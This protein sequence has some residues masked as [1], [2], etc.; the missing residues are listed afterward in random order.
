M[1]LGGYALQ[2]MT[3]YLRLKDVLSSLILL[4]ALKHSCSSPVPTE[5][6]I[7]VYCPRLKTLGVAPPR[8][9]LSKSNRSALSRIVSQVAAV[10]LSELSEVVSGSQMSLHK[11]STC[12]SF[13]ARASKTQ[14]Q[15]QTG[16]NRG[17]PSLPSQMS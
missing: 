7:W 16:A 3:L 6:K 10:H 4:A 1:S 17:I 2:S 15:T 9:S 14:L 8:L 5:H 13:L 11:P 12:V